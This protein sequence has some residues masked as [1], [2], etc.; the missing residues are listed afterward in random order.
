M[1]RS[2]L[3]GEGSPCLGH[4]LRTSCLGV[5]NTPGL[6]LGWVSNLVRRF[7]GARG[8][9]GRETTI[10]LRFN[11]HPV[12]VIDARNMTHCT[13]KHVGGRI[14]LAVASSCTFLQSGLLDFI[15]R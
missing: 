11:N 15:P 3:E 6:D 4:G 2:I 8:T 9:L 5:Q 1:G 7:R 14:T 13:D 12:D 10:L